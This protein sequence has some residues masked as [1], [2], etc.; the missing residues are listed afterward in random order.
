MPH[1][2]LVRHGQANTAARDEISYDRLSDLGHQQ[3]R[4]LGEHM[5]ASGD[6]FARIYCGSLQR[7]RET[8]E[9]MGLAADAEVVVDPRFNEFPYFALAQLLE[10]QQGLPVPGVRE[11]FVTHLP[12]LL[13]AWQHDEIAEAPESH[14][15]FTDRITDAMADIA[16]GE[17]RAVVVTSGG[18]IGGVMRQTLGLTTE[19]WAQVC[20]AIMNTSVHRWQ[21]LEGRPMLA[22]F[23]AIP[24]LE[25]P[26]RQFAQT[27]L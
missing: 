22:Q 8:A 12:R 10:A 5:T 6:R 18:V 3:A 23:N 9:S 1:I 25:T 11:N 7:H 24:H 26:K 27:H 2:T 14:G 13:T 19:G 16:A 15:D 4:W 17:G 20:L 21:L